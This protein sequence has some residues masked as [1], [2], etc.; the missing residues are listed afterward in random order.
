MLSV[1]CPNC[2]SAQYYY[3]V[4]AFIQVCNCGVWKRHFEQFDCI[5]LLLLPISI[6][7][8]HVAIF[9]Y[10]LFQTLQLIWILHYGKENF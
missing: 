7:Y 1:E 9:D 5:R 2:L 3:F 8:L 6:L 4:Y 10:F